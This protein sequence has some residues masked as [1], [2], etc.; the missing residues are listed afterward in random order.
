MRALRLFAMTASTALLLG[1]A[2]ASAEGPASL[3]KLLRP[4]ITKG[5]TPFSAASRRHPLADPGGRIPVMVSL[6]NGWDP[7]GFGLLPLAPG[8]GTIRLAPDEVEIFAAS[9]P[10]FVV[11]VSPPRRPLLDVSKNWTKATSYRDQTGTDGTGVVVGV[12]D[13]GIDVTHPDFRDKNGKT[14]IAWLLRAGPPVGLHPELEARFG[15]SDP[16]Q[17]A[18]AIYSAADIDAEI[19]AGDTEIR[20][21]TGH[22]THVASIAAGNGGLGVFAPGTL[23]AIC[24]GTNDCSEGVCLDSGSELICSHSCATTPECASGT[25]CRKIE[26]HPENICVRIAPHYIGVAPGATLVVAAPSPPGGGFY[27]PDILNAANFVFD[28]AAALGMPAVLN[29]SIGGDFGPHDGSS[30]LETGLASLVGDDKP[31]RA[32]TVAAGNSGALY[33]ADDAGPFGVHTEAHVSD[34]AVTRV[35]IRA[36]ECKDGQGFVWVTFRSGDEISVGL[37]G[38]GGESWVG[39]VAPGDEGAEERADGTTGAVINNVVDGETAITEGTNSAILAWDGAWEE[40]DFAVRLQGKGDAQL[41][42]VGQGAG[43]DSLYFH[44]ALKQGTINV[45][46]SHP[47]LL[48]VGCTVNRLSWKPLGDAAIELTSLGGEPDPQPDG[49]CYFSSAGPT[50]F[51]VAKPEIS[52]PGGFVAGAMAIDADPR[53]SP[54]GLFD[55]SGCPEQD[56]PC[57]IVDENHAITAGTSMSAPH[58]AGAIALLF[59]HDGD[60]TQARV[61]EILQAGARYPSGRV[62]TPVQ[63][64]PGE[65]DLDGALLALQK[66]EFAGEPDVRKSWYVLSSQY[67]RPDPTWPVWGTVELR[68]LDG[69]IASGL[70]GTKLTLVVDGGLVIQPPVKVHHG[71]FRF[72]I[73]GARGSGRTT[74][75]VD[76]LYDGVSLCGAPSDG[77]CGPQALAIGNDA[78]AAPGELEAL[79]GDCSCRAAGAAPL[80]QSGGRLGLLALGGLMAALRLARGRRRLPFHSGLFR[81]AAS[82]AP[83]NKLSALR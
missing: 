20:D 38:P 40:G 7:G 11:R 39:L 62:S 18:C 5:G 81:P 22:G 43:C 25:H 61:T 79:G 35:P 4:S 75:S 44:K 15:C 67:A 45:P 48:A 37:E 9:N 70:D 8:V 82:R 66:E 21:L 24:T 51:G 53:T 49:M 50:P 3:I 56:K 29:L 77:P 41:W 23:G 1:S 59:Q 6:P 28:R 26:G 36:T 31:G 73:A 47:R 19:A 14:R 60:L 64:G 10:G 13:T 16:S 52:A 42:V 32:I 2:S 74:M 65:L 71:L 83:R 34:Y 30:V 78:W 58:V 57:Y 55:P 54:G 12:I 76:V 69:T 17:S 46:A 80:N 27:D 33:V 68:R 72:A 63:L